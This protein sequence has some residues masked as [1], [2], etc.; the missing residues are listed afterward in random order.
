M[1]RTRTKKVQKKIVSENL[2]AFLVSE[3][4]HVRYLCGFAATESLDCILLVF[5]NEAHLITDFRYREQAAEQAKGVDVHIADRKLLDYIGRLRPLHTPPYIK[6]GYEAL[7]LVDGV[8][9]GLQERLPRAIFIPTRDIIEDLAMVKDRS[10]LASIKEA[11][12]ISDTAFE[13]I[14]AI[15]RPGIRETELAAELEYQMRM[16]GSEKAAFETIVASGYRGALPH[17]LA[18]GKKVKKG[19]FITFDFGATYNGYTS[20][21]TRTVVVGKAT[22]RQKKIYGVV[23]KAQ[24]KAISAAKAGI[25]GV[26][27]D[28]IAR[29]IISRA[30]YAKRFGHGLGHGIGLL[31]HEKPTLSPKSDST[32]APGNVVTIEPGIYIPNWGGV[33]IEDDVVIRRGGCTVLNKAPKELL[34]L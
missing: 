26:K 22:A 6:I 29:D 24:Q 18:S 27:L 33:R 16:L 19:E 32:L 8:L 10:E 15:I 14:L 3:L 2:D 34:E 4:A 12:R 25:T 5:R 21:I 7:Y 9:K 31:V 13:R 20:D 1:F 30:G 17:G 11:V 23:A 28:S